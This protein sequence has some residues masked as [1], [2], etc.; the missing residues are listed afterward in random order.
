MLKMKIQ[1]TRFSS[2]TNSTLGV[3]HNVTGKPQFLCYT[4]EDEHRTVKV[5]G[6]TRIPQGTYKLRIRQYGGFHE[7]YKLKYNAFHKGMIEVC[8]VPG[9]K[10]ILFHVGNSDDDT[11][12]CILL[13]D[14][15]RQN[16]TKVGMIYNSVDAYERV[17]RFIMGMMLKGVNV[18]LIIKDLA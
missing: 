17:Y 5:W 18:E 1:L 12:G 15:Q 4:L 9:F 3:L 8:G 11:A 10:D 2:D 7:R 6:E 13:G 16:L 14:S